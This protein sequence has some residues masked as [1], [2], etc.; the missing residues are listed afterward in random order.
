MAAPTETFIQENRGRFLD[1]LKQFIRIP[2]ISTLPEHAGDIQR[3]AAFVAESLQRAGMEHVEIIPTAGHPLVYADWLHAPGKPTVLCYGH[4]DVQPADPLEQWISPPFEPAERNGNLYARGAVDDKGQ[5]YMHIK[6][7]EALRA[8]GGALPVNLK[9]LIEG[10]EEIGGASV[11]KFVAENAEKLRADVALVSDTAM[12]AEGMP[13][14]CIGLRGLIYLEVVA[15]GPA[16][17]L[18]SGL[19]GGAAPN[20]VYGLV[21]L[22]AKAKD[23]NG[24]VLISGIYDDVIEPAPAELESWKRLPFDEGEFLRKEVGATALTGEPGRSVLERT[25]SRPTFEVHG[26]A[27]GFTGAGAKTVIPAQATA[28]VS[29]RLVPRQQPEKVIAAFR[30]WVCAAAPPGIRAEVR[31]LSASP[32]LVVNPDHPAIATAARAFSEVFGRDTVFVRSGGSIPIV[33]DFAA[34]LGIPTVLMGF[35]LPDDGLHSPNEKYKIENYY[36]GIRTVARFLE[37]MGN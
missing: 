21:Q 16:R 13:T 36:L 28:K 24:A 5:M 25:W 34:H 29:F 18:H 37:M 22:L 15:S 10:E 31:V 23:K 17:D 9:F 3:A 14:L 30:D 32:G 33:G 7:V 35:G 11:A 27:G 4:Y 12:Y 2:S 19:Y 6:A 8:A 1:E 20:A 26:I